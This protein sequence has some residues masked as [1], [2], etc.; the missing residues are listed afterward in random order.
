MKITGIELIPLSMVFKAAIEESFGTVGKREDNVIVRLH[1]DEG[2]SGIG[3]GST[4]GPFYCGESQ[5]TV[6]GIISHHIYP[7]LLEGEDPFN[8]DPIHYKMNKLV[9]GNTVAKAAVDYA[10]HDIMG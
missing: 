8:I 7:K 6:M 1:T 3:E 9:Y 5:E 10:I 4:L 2:I